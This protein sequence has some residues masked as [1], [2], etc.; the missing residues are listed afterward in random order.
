M[1]SLSNHEGTLLGTKLARKGAHQPIES[2]TGE[3]VDKAAVK[4]AGI[5]RNAVEKALKS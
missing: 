1:V 5:I 2:G 4:S 3:D